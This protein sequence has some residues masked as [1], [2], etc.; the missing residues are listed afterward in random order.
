[1]IIKGPGRISGD[2]RRILLIQLGD[3]GDVVLSFPAILALRERFPAARIVT[4]VREKA[5]ELIKGCPWTTDVLIVRTGKGSLRHKD[6]FWWL[7][8]QP[9]DLAVDLRTGTRGAILTLLSRAPQRIG[10]HDP[11]GSFWRNRI[12]THLAA[13]YEPPGK[14]MAE[15]YANLLKEYNV[16]PS[17]PWPVIHVSDAQVKTA[18]ELFDAEKIPE[19]SPAV[20]VQP[21]S[22]WRYKEWG[23]DKY[24]GLIQ[25]IRAGS[26]VPVL[27]IGSAD[28]RERA[29]TIK[30]RS[31]S[32][33]YNISGK[34]SLG[35][36]GAV[37]KRCA[38]FVGGD[39]AGM[40]IAAG[41]G[42][43]TV[44][45]FGPSSAS[46]W[47]PRGDIH[48]VV[49]KDYPCLPCHQKGCDGNGISRCLEELS[50][51]EVFS[52]LP[53]PIKLKTR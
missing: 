11:N 32:G 17:R 24:A 26:D 34:T 49:R 18:K 13:P 47:A 7:K 25:Q 22:L 42:T 44:T 27:I 8:K 45:I 39:S 38:F 30:N 43:P 40:H 48:R 41:V 12:F 14:H 31:G 3:I 33:V 53:L 1:M 37:L 19:G 51:E 29:E 16:V 35:L 23:V 21:F 15:V 9:F 2:I 5:G 28:E 46:D 6:C 20:A 50:V 4:A 52:A 36:L 10:F